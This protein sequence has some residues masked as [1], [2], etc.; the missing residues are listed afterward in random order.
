MLVAECPEVLISVEELLLWLAVL[1]AEEEWE[2]P[3][4]GTTTDEADW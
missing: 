1:L 3:P 2:L 4:L